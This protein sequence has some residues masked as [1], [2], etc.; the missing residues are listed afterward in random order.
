[1]IFFARR[2]KS[3]QTIFV[4][5]TIYA[6]KGWPTAHLLFFYKYFFKMKFAV[7]FWNELIVVTSCKLRTCSIVVLDI[8]QLSFLMRVWSQHIVII[9]KRK[10]LQQISQ[11]IWKYQSEKLQI[12]SLPMIFATKTIVIGSI[13]KKNYSFSQYIHLSVLHWF[14]AAMFII[15][16]SANNNEINDMQCPCIA[17]YIVILDVATNK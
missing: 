7:S 2:I 10:P 12:F 17:N 11:I 15:K 14:F 6:E 8:K 1:M 3:M 5:H 13:A 4:T 16:W 9:N